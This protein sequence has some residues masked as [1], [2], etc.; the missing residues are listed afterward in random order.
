MYNLL[1]V[2]LYN[3]SSMETCE[4]PDKRI[5]TTYKMSSYAIFNKPYCCFAKNLDK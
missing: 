1:D 4:A 3:N 2:D 5:S